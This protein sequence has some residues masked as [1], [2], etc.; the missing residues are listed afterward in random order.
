M[1]TN[2]SVKF[3]RVKGKVVPISQDKYGQMSQSKS[4]RDQK[5]FKTASDS[6]SRKDAVSALRSKARSAGRTFSLK[7][8]ISLRGSMTKPTNEAKQYRYDAKRIQ[9]GLG[10]GKAK[11]SESAR[12][13]SAVYFNGLFVPPPPQDGK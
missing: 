13:H 4:K 12:E 7:Q 6:V 11:Y 9:K 2:G 1:I 10:L 5:L 8:F 3:I